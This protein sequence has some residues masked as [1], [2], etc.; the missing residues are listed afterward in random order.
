MDDEAGQ[1][2]AYI[3]D[4]AKETNRDLSSEMTTNSTSSTSHKDSSSA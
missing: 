3:D 4:L 2:S 1:Q